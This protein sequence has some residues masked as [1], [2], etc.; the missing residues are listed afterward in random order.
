[1]NTSGHS[2]LHQTV[3]TTATDLWN[4]SCSVQEL[5]Y[6]LQHGASGATTNPTIVLQVL[7]KEMSHWAP[8]I[9]AL[10]AQ[11]PRW[12]ED[13]LAQALFE[14]VSLRGAALL[15]PVFQREAGRKGRL[16]IQTNPCLY[17]DWRGI[18]DHA[19]HYHGLA[20]NMQV[21][22]PATAAGIRAVEESTFAGVNINATVCFTVP[23]ALAVAE[24]VERGLQ[25]RRAAGHDTGGMTPVC[26]IMVGRTDDWLKVIMKRDGVI[27]EPG[28][29]DQAGIAVI[30][31]AYRL[32]QER[33]YRT[34]LL[35]AAYRH[36]MHWSALIGGDLILTIPYAWQL[37]FNRSDITVRQRMHEPVDPRIVDRLLAC[38]PDFVRAWEEDGLSVSE[39]DGYGATVRTLRSFI[40]SWHALQA[41]VRDHMLPDPD[42]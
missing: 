16:S 32:Y 11:H 14:E 41:L 1:M 29:L 20:P 19:L 13:R 12:A 24:A 10:I 39:F 28:Y 7:R 8:R 35:A 17:R 38:F 27:V 3:H 9:P 37:R 30:K 21:K 5:A 23:Q 6:A 34:R 31:K 25:R 22:I 2:P 18:T 26:T 36:H 42:L 4:D 40:N 15:M 33:G